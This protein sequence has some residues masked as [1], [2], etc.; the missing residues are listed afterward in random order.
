MKQTLV[1]SGICMGLAFSMIGCAS[2]PSEGAKEAP[3]VPSHEE[4]CVRLVR[5]LRLF[6]KDGLRNGKASRGVDCLS[7]RLELRKLCY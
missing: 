1:W 2:S 4:R 3:A 6:C 7:R 5:D